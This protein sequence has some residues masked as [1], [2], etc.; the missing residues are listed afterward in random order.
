MII[1][2]KNFLTLWPYSNNSKAKLN[3]ITKWK[4][5]TWKNLDIIKIINGPTFSSSKRVSLLVNWP[6][7]KLHF[8]FNLRSINCI[9]CEKKSVQQRLP[10]KALGSPHIWNER[11]HRSWIIRNA[12]PRYR[13]VFECPGILRLDLL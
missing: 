11:R 1:F 8:V 12:R 3:H 6:H 5:K 4:F 9:S 2:W 7:S 13:M 10:V